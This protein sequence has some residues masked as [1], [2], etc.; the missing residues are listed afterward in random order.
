M[1]GETGRTRSQDG[2]P[3]FAL[4]LSVQRNSSIL[5]QSSFM[6]RMELVFTDSKASFS[7]NL[8]IVQSSRERHGIWPSLESSV[9]DLLNHSA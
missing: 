3:S 6:Q 4:L 2:P 1:N 9:Y 7:S 5:A 8:G